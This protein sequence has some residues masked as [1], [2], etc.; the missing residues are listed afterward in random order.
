M[1]EI[2]QAEFI[3][4]IKKALNR[5]DS[6]KL[7]L[8][9]IIQRVPDSADSALLEEI[10]GRGKKMRLALLDQLA[11]TGRLL[12][13]VVTTEKDA[14]SAA[15]SILRIAVEKNSEWGDKKT[16]VAWDHPLVRSLDLSERLQA[17]DIPVHYPDIELR[18]NRQ[19]EFSMQA[20]SSFIGI[21]SADY[22]IAQTATL[23]MKTRVGQ[24]RCVSLLPS[25]HIAVIKLEQ[26]LSDLKELYTLLKWDPDEQAEGITNCM[27]FITGPSK[28]ADI[29]ATLVDGA[30]G[31]RELYLFVIK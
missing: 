8:E 10:K 3:G 6:C 16:I 24:P 17:H 26:I 18:T 4:N 27:T 23:T 2:G 5:E 31:P 15:A 9:D 7:T 30:H 13:M 22:C 28:T 29:E 1:T 19:K 25:I 11:E 14:T 21:T 20:A 12:N